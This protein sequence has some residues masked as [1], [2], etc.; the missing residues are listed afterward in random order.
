M[1]KK[2]LPATW[3]KLNARRFDP[4]GKLPEDFADLAGSVMDMLPKPPLAVPIN[5]AAIASPENPRA[6]WGVSES[7]RLG[8]AL[9]LLN[10]FETGD[11]PA[12]E[13]LAKAMRYL[14]DH[15]MPE[16]NPMGPVIVDAIATASRENRDVSKKDIAAKARHLI[17][18]PNKAFEFFKKHGLQDIGQLR[19]PREKQDPAPPKNRPGGGI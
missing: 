3:T 11:I 1:K 6:E 5:P 2:P 13:N 12:I 9:N 19:G 14:R 17:P 4:R 10:L 15:P 18:P 7:M 16:I 8:L